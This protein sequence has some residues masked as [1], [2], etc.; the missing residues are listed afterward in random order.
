MSLNRIYDELFFNIIVTEP[1]VFKNLLFPMNQFKPLKISFIA[2]GCFIL[3]GY[4]TINAQELISTAGNSHSNTNGSISYTIGEPVIETF[5]GA[6]NILTQGFQQSNLVVTAIDELPGLDFEISAFPNPATEIVKLR[7]GKESAIGMQ[8]MLYDMNGNLLMK[9]RLEGTE[10]KIPFSDLS[11][12]E[13]I[14][15]VSNQDKELKS[16][17]IVKIK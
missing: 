6:N 10:T 9:N 8:Y 16:F 13:Y 12:A 5:A 1:T 15:I 4:G 14:L 17:R 3:T 2:I 7:I 11:A